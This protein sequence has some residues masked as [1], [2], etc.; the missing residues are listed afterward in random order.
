[1][2]RKLTLFLVCA[3]EVALILFVAAASANAGLFDA[4]TYEDCVLENMEK[5]KTEQALAEVPFGGKGHI[6]VHFSIT[7][8][9]LLAGI[10]IILMSSSL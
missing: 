5:A 1:M 10:S 8:A 2:T 4:N 6:E 9:K 3:F 7:K